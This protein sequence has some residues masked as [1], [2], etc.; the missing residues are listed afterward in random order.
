MIPADSE[1]WNTEWGKVYQGVFQWM[2]TVDP[3]DTEKQR[4]AVEVLK[5]LN[6][7]GDADSTIQ[8]GFLGYDGV[9]FGLSDGRIVMHNRSAMLAVNEPKSLAD[10]KKAAK[11]EGVKVTAE[12]TKVKKPSRKVG[13]S[14]TKAKGSSK[15]LDNQSWKQISE[16]G[17]SQP[18]G[19]FE[20]SSGKKFYVKKQKSQLHA[21]NEVLMSKLYER[22]GI[23]AAKNS[24]GTAHI[25]GH[26]PG[27]GVFSE[28]LVGSQDI[29]RKHDQLI[30]DPKWKKSVQDT[31]VA[32]AWLANWD[33]TG[34]AANIKMGADGEAYIVDTGGGGLF[35]ARG[36]SKGSSFGPIVGEMESLRDRGL[37]PLGAMY[38]GDISPQEIAR[39]VAVIGALSDADIRMMVNATVTDSVEAKKLV[40]TLIA[41]RD[42]LVNTW[43]TGI[44]K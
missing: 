38:Y 23:R 29:S 4:K 10:I 5:L 27:P 40:D 25:K 8:A 22:L 41:R 1:V 30:R 2:K 33:A 37:N 16:Q 9:D 34:N 26:S 13:A 7:I 11:G 19:G 36:D 18:G 12:K 44:R 14:S 35:R 20:D 32:N 15:S 24:G 31:F 3:K 17:G 39:Q 6:R 42:Y 28:W 43:G 21:E